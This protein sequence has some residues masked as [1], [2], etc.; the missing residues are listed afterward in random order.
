MNEPFRCGNVAIVGRPNVGKSTLLNALVDAHLS[1]V[2]PRA[3]TTRQRIL[4]IANPAGGQIVYLDT[5]GLHREAKRAINRS[6]N[7]AVHAAIADADVA[8]QVVAA[9]RWDDEDAAVYAALAERDIPRLLAVNKVDRVAAKEKLLPFVETLVRDRAWDEVF[10]VSAQRR[11]G[12]AE[13]ERAILVR[14][15]G[16]E[17]RYDAESYT[18]RSERFLAAELVREQLMRQLGEELPYATTVEIERFEDRADGLTEI[19][20]VVWVEREGQKAIVI[21][22]GGR[23]AKAIG[24]AARRA[25]EE[26]LGRRVFL[27]LWVRVRAGWSDDEAALKQFGYE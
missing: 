1:I 2:T 6:L 16:G 5:P 3:H 11:I 7:R 15:P 17:A 27:K 14:L 26:L 20:A 10:M 21:G 8:V 25:I 24:S 23:R 4:G 22:A 9:E 13:L 18:D 12:L 19:A